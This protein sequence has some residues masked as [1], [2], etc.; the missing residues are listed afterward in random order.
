MARYYKTEQEHNEALKMKIIDIVQS[1]DETW[2]LS[3]ILRSIK[4]ITE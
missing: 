1:V 2:L 4:C 3:L